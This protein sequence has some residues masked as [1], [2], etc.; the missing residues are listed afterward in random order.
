MMCVD[1]L[2]DGLLPLAGLQRNE[3][4]GAMLSARLVR[5]AVALVRTLP[6]CLVAADDFANTGRTRLVEHVEGARR[7]WRVQTTAGLLVNWTSICC[8]FA[9]SRAVRSERCKVVGRWWLEISRSRGSRGEER[10]LKRQKIRIKKND[11]RRRT[12]L[13]GMKKFFSAADLTVQWLSPTLPSTSIALNCKTAWQSVALGP[14]LSCS[15]FSQTRWSFGIKSRDQAIA[16]GSLVPAEISANKGRAE[17]TGSTPPC[18]GRE[19]RCHP[20]ACGA[21]LASEG[22]AHKRS[23]RLIMC[24]LRKCEF[25]TV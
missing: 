8:E 2:D 23:S 1:G 16:I 25:L 10:Q 19:L 24:R 6:P 9:G 14:G 17:V 7:I 4:C 12:R 18:V 5:A 22:A 21:E 11:K 3:V 13:Q 20:G 15:T